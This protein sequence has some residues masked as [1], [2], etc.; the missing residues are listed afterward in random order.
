MSQILMCDHCGE[1]FS[2]N[3]DGWTEYTQKIARPSVNG[4][5]HK[6]MHI[7]PKHQQVNETIKP[8]L[9]L[10]ASTDE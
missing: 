4:N 8:R 6:V 2:V 10:E 5:T 7:C 9:A 3:E 1:V